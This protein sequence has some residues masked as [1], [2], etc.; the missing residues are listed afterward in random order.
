MHQRVQSEDLDVGIVFDVDV[1]VRD[2]DGIDMHLD[3]LPDFGVEVIEVDLHVTGADR[4]RGAVL[5]P[6]AAGILR[7]QR[8]ADG[9]KATGGVGRGADVVERR[10]LGMSA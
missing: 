10:L 4:E 9:F 1:D 2:D 7:A 6:R 5:V 8:V 3:I